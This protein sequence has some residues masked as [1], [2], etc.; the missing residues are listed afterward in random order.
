MFAMIPFKRYQKELD[1]LIAARSEARE[2]P[3]LTVEDLYNVLAQFDKL[4]ADTAW[5]MS[6]GAKSRPL[7]YR[8][9]GNMDCPVTHNA[10]WFNYVGQ[11]W[12]CT[13]HPSE[14]SDG[15]EPDDPEPVA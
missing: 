9:D 15:P 7:Y 6:V 4:F 8:G 12:P 2:S 3:F 13:G 10:L 5:A 14:V 1:A 11:H